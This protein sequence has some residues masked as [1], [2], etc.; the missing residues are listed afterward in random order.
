[1]A[2]W[3][4][5]L[6]GVVVLVFAVVMCIR[7]RQT[8][9]WFDEVVLKLPLIGTLVG[10]LIFARVVRVWAAMLRSHVP[11]LDTIR[12]SRAAV[13]NA[14]FLRL[15]ANVEESVSSGGRMGQAVAAAGLADPVVVSA[16]RTGEDNGRLAEATDFVSD[17][18]DDDNTS[19]IQQITRL[20]EPVLLAVMG[21]IVGFVAM[22]LFLPLFDLAT[23][24]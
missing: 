7:M 24:A 12:Q 20:V 17:W 9:A 21:V 18:M 13:T 8:R 16:I 2:G 5:I 6:G 15:L 19:L 10:R 14:A 11:L 22:G 23:A 4:Y 3:P 1:M